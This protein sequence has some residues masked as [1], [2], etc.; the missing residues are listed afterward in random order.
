MDKNLLIERIFFFNLFNDINLTLNVQIKIF[1][2]DRFKLY[3]F[4]KISL[5]FNINFIHLLTYNIKL[6]SV[7]LTDTTLTSFCKTDVHL[8]IIYLN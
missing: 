6:R 1:K 4:N 8:N 5:E 3:N 7:I 2:I